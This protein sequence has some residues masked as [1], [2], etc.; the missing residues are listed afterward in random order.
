MKIHIIF[1]FQ[2]GPYGGGNQFLKA[3]KK[4]FDEQGLYTARPSEADIFLFNSFQDVRRVIALKR[5]HQNAQFIH[6]VDGPIALYRG[7]NKNQPDNIIYQLN[8]DI[9]DATIFQSQFSFRENI[10]LGMKPPQRYE[11]IFNACDQSI[12]YPK[13]DRD[14]NVEHRK[15]RLISASW[16]SNFLKG[17]NTYQ[18]LDENLDFAK[19]D[20]T[21]VGRSPVAFKH[22]QIVP[23]QPSDVVADLMRGSDIYITASQKDPCSNSLIE[24]LTCGLPAIALNDGGHPELLRHGGELFDDPP[25]ISSKLTRIALNYRSY[26]RDIPVFSLDAI[27][28]KYFEFIDEIYQATQNKDYRAKKLTLFNAARLRAQL[29]LSGL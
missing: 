16:S 18:Y 24:A 29:L 22:I 2:S 17:F 5:K 8:N 15:I 28:R 11:I 3:L 12:F 20:Y 19:Y 4:N 21:F 25:E 27:S 13:T 26:V 9:A 6:R 14:L 23:P 10:R 1:P 7:S